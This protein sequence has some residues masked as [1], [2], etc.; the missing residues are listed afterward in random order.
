MVWTH[1][2]KELNMSTSYAACSGD[3]PV[4]AL[5]VTGGV[6]WGDVYEYVDAGE[7]WSSPV[8]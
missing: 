8:A 2:W 5:T 3:A 7:W 6:Q 4:P 1:R